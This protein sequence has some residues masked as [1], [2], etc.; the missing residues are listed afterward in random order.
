M[1]QRA[2]LQRTVKTMGSNGLESFTTVHIETLHF[3]SHLM[4][5][6]TGPLGI[7]SNDEPGTSRQALTDRSIVQM[8]WAADSNDK[9]VKN[10]DGEFDL[11]SATDAFKEQVNRLRV[12]S[13]LV[14]YV[15]V[16]IKHLPHLRPNL[17]YARQLTDKWDDIMYDEFNLPR[18]SPRK[19]IKRNM[20]FKHFA[21]ESAVVEWCLWRHTAID[22]EAMLPDQNGQ[23][24]SFCIDQLAD[25]IRSM[26][27]CLD[28]E[29]ILNAWSHNLAHSA[30]TASHTLELKT[31]LAQLHGEEL[32]NRTLEGSP[33]PP[34]KRPRTDADGV[35]GDDAEERELERAMAAAGAAPPPPP[36]PDAG[37]PQFPDLAGVDAAGVDAAG[38]DAAGVDAAGVDVEM[39]GIPLEAPRDEHGNAACDVVHIRGVMHNGMTRRDCGRLAEQLEA[40]RQ[41]RADYSG[42]LVSRAATGAA[43]VRARRGAAAA[44]A[45]RAT[46]R[47]S[48]RWPRQ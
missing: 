20:L 6:N 15:L 9:S 40:Q 35:A 3:E 18:P 32:D 38:V 13:C 30:P 29:V 22:F 31:V 33:L 4:T 10:S 24:S 28:H 48:T 27:R 11:E 14:A 17:T 45:A 5:T 39:A 23:L 26:Q 12:V 19:K 37:G 8:V 2:G 47:R 43:P 41:L 44:A 21:A 34:A 1:E 42:R 25:V 46:G 7:R 16:F 36:P